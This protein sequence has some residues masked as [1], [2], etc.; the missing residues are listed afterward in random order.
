[1][2]GE[3]RLGFKG[4]LMRESGF[5]KNTA[6]FFLELP[7]G[8]VLHPSTPRGTHRTEGGPDLIRVGVTTMG[9]GGVEP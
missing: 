3:M 9:R 8:L 2:K 5:V 6:V 7:Q 1:M 4:L